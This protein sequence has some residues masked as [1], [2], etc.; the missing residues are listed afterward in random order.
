MGHYY[1]ILQHLF[2]LQASAI[3]I[4]SDVTV[5]FVLIQHWPAMEYIMIAVITAMRASAHVS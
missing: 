1:I 5:D 4:S 2:A 3:P